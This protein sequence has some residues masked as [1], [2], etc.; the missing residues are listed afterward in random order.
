MKINTSN[1]L[2]IIFSIVF[3]L[4]ISLWVYLLNEGRI[5]VYAII[6][7]VS[8]LSSSF[9]FNPKGKIW[10][11]INIFFIGCLL[12]FIGYEVYRYFTIIP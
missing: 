6:L 7:S 2:S 10:L 3:S 11:V 12:F 5:S 4:I 9:I 8:V 1:S